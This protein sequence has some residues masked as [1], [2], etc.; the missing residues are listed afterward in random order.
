MRSWCRAGTAITG[1]PPTVEEVDVIELEPKVLEA[2][3]SISSW[4]K[5][6]PLDDPRATIYINDAR[7]AL[8]LTAKKYDMIVSQPSHPW[9]AGASHLYTREYMQMVSDHLNAGGVFLQWINSQFVDAFPEEL[10][11]TRGRRRIEAS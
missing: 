9:S 3:R 7:S 4:R 2:N 11:Q 5:Y 1:L 6:Q 10:H 8:A